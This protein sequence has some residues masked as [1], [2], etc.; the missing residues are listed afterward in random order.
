MKAR[1]D[2]K[3]GYGPVL[4][5][6]M[7][8]KKSSPVPL[9]L[10]LTLLGAGGYFGWKAYADRQ[11][12]ARARAEAY[13]RELAE[14][15]RRRQ[16][17]L[18]AEEAA[19]NKKAVKKAADAV[20]PEQP[21]VVEKTEADWLREEESRRKAVWLEIVA[22]QT[23]AP[24]K[25]VNGFAGIRFDAPLADGG[26]VCWGTVLPNG[27][28]ESV[29]ARG[30]AFAVY[31]PKLKKPFLSL[32]TQPLAWVTP[33]TRRP[34]RVE[35]KRPIKRSAGALHD[36]ETT[37]LVAFLEKRFSCRAYAP[38]PANPAR[39][40]CEYVIPVGPALLHVME[41]DGLLSFSVERTDL[42]EVARQEAAQLR[43]ERTRVADADQI[44]NSTR[45]P[46]GKIDLSKYPKI[47]LKE[48]TPRAFCGIVFSAPPPENA[49]LF[50]PQKGAKGFYLDYERAKIPSFAG[51]RYGKA[52]YDERRGG[53]FAVRLISDGGREGQSDADYFA[54]VRGTLSERYGVKPTETKTDLGFPVLTYQVGDVLITFGPDPRGGFFLNA[55]NSVLAALARE[56]DQK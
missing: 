1:N 3:M 39:P 23:N 24:A 33:K 51:F 50:N 29:E 9:L 52:E 46:R 47:R 54:S 53:V 12:A 27:A 17:E 55:E 22:A 19:R 43:Q 38:Q 5:N 10:L 20:R 40:G 2:V 28:G 7:P 14:Q 42:M 34:F 13:R 44:L 25:P 30:A 11:A 48:G 6:E 32:G 16:E 26:A 21:R 15:E 56:P 45:Y 18:A 36:P 49:R 35:F 37:N 8:K 31:G 41:R 4:S